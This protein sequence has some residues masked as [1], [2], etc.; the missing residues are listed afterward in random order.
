MT[1]KLPYIVSSALTSSQ[2]RQALSSESNLDNNYY[3]LSE[4]QLGHVKG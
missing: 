4:L 2:N 1:L 3:Y